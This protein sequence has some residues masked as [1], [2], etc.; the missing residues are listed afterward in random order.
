M[1]ID[2]TAQRPDFQKTQSAPQSSGENRGYRVYVG[3]IPDFSE[4]VDGMKISGVREKSPA[5]KAGLQTG[6]IIIKFGKYSIKSLYD[7]STAIQEY[8]PGDTVNVFWKRGLETKI[9]PVVLE[10]RK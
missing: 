3:T 8:K 4:T 1:C 2:T 7:Y 5:A 10:V 6:D 9:A